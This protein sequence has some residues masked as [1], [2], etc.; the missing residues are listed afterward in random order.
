MFLETVTVRRVL[1]ELEEEAASGCLR[2]IYA[3]SIAERE[4]YG[5]WQ[6]GTDWSRSTN[7]GGYA[8]LARRDN[9]LR[10][11]FMHVPTQLQ[12]SH[13]ANKRDYL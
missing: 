13:L 8:S 2:S 12:C 10:H 5:L 3:L 11:N 9:I 1:G 4:A 6:E 7:Q